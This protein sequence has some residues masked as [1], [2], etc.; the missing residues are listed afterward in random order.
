M[1]SS[2]TYVKV[3]YSL[4]WRRIEAKFFVILAQ[5]GILL[6]M[7]TAQLF[8]W[9]L[10]RMIE[11][12]GWTQEDFAGKVGLTPGRVSQLC[13]AKKGIPGDETLDIFCR[14][15]NCEVEDFFKKP[16][17]EVLAALKTLST[18][19]F[20]IPETLKKKDPKK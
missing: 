13:N 11:E 4:I 17:P 6:K 16:D 7:L 15:F 2:F 20:E 1:A 12:R 14:V 19:G 5:S 10:R 3:I 9:N 18:H 8:A